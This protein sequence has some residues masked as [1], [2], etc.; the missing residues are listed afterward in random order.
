VN[1]TDPLKLTVSWYWPETIP[2]NESIVI[3]GR[4]PAAPVVVPTMV[5]LGV[6]KVPLKEDGVAVPDIATSLIFNRLELVR[7]PPS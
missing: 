2:E 6:V 4:F 1:A 5:P 3:V 7:T